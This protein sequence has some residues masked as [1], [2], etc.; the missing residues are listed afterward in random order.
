[1][2]NYGTLICPC[3]GTL[4]NVVINNIGEAHA[5]LENPILNTPHS[6]A[7]NQIIQTQNTNCSMS[8]LINSIKSFNVRFNKLC[9]K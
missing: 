7:T 3:C 4:L 9:D 8:D 2:T 6:L 1:M 5:M